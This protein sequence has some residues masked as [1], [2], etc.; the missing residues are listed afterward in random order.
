M[1]TRECYLKLPTSTI[2]TTAWPCWALPTLKSLLW[3]H[4]TKTNRIPSTWRACSAKY[5]KCEGWHPA[6]SGHGD[7]LWLPVS[8][9]HD[10]GP[11]PSKGGS[12]RGHGHDCRLA[13]SDSLSRDR[14]PPFSRAPTRR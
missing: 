3:L 13:G 1:T 4:H 12:H 5:W 8:P 11:W 7:V 14:Q 6:D 10:R 9:G 2:S